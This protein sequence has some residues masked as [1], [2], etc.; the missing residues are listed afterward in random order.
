VAWVPAR[1]RHDAAPAPSLDGRALVIKYQVACEA[2]VVWPSAP[3]GQVRARRP[4]RAADPRDR[5]LESRRHGRRVA[6]RPL[7]AG[8]EGSRLAARPRRLIW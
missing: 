8:D 3:C 4:G 7:R 2:R 6:G 5:A 1:Q